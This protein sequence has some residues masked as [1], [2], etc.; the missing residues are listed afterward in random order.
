MNAMNNL[1][2]EE[3]NVI[4]TFKNTESDFKYPPLENKKISLRNEETEREIEMAIC[5]NIRNGVALWLPYS[6]EIVLQPL[7]KYLETLLDWGDKEWAEA[8]I[9]KFADNAD[10]M[11]KDLT[12]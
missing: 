7:Y 4:A 1:F 11:T 6:S 9:D 3:W 5:E 8:V 2:N 12:N 10:F